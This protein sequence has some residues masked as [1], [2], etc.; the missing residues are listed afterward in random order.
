M[1]QRNPNNSRGY[2]RADV[3]HEFDQVVRCHLRLVVR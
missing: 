3:I 2:R 1:G